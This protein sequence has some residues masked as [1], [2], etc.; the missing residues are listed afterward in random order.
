MTRYQSCP[1]VVRRN[2]LNDGDTYSHGFHEMLP[3][4]TTHM[5]LYIS[6][7]KAGKLGG[8]TV[9]YVLNAGD[10]ALVKRIMDYRITP[11]DVRRAH[12]REGRHVVQKNHFNRE[13]WDYIAGELKGVP[14][15][16]IQ[17]APEGLV[18]PVPNVVTQIRN[19]HPDFP[20][21]PMYFEPFWVRKWSTCGS[22]TVSHVV[23][24]IHRRQL[25]ACS[26]LAGDALE[27]V[28]KTRLHDFGARGAHCTEHAEQGG[29]AH[30]L[31]YYGTDTEAAIAFLEDLYADALDGML[32][33]S[34]PAASHATY[35]AW[36]EN[37]GASAFVRH[38][39]EKWG[40]GGNLFAIVG[41]N[42]DLKEFVRNLPSCWMNEASDDGCLVVRPDSGDMM[43]IV[44]W[45]MRTLANDFGVNVNKKGYAVLD[46]HVAAIQ[47]D[48]QKPGTIYEMGWKVIT[49]E[50]IS[51]ESLA[52]GMG[53]FLY[54]GFTRDTFGWA[55]KVSS[56]TQ[57][58]V[59]Y[60]QWKDPVT[61]PGKASRRGPQALVRTDEEGKFG[62]DTIREDEAGRRGLRNY[63]DTIWLDGKDTTEDQLR[64]V[65]ARTEDFDRRLADFAE[66]PAAYEA[67]KA[68]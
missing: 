43:E 54:T 47:G 51:V 20:A 3:P 65:R 68:A 25:E 8:V 28:L 37:G 29:A 60:D 14:P 49:E 24:Q 46:S 39:A 13:G 2:W 18:V 19:T 64:V 23:K 21:L 6:P 5:N 16:Q 22:G 42:D 11:D 52:N 33:C 58:G 41:D 57:G 4:G 61:D 56:R 45:T 10:R 55:G 7:R 9:P 1:N 67:Q 38:C 36:R 17:S 63:L 59:A 30:L 50:K 26:D 66:P 31:N 62:W 53:G 32:S 40:H 44:P 48:G 27:F 35:G 12:A 34:I 15:L